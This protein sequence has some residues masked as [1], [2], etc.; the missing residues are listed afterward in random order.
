MSSFGYIIN[1]VDSGAQGMSLIASVYVSS[2]QTINLVRTSKV[3]LYTNSVHWHAYVATYVPKERNVIYPT[4][5]LTVTGDTLS[6]II[7]GASEY[8]NVL[9]FGV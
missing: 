9:F 5:T 4:V 7:H 3:L 1:G 8:F 6:A 2:G